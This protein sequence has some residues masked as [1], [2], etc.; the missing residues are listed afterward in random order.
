MKLIK[1]KASIL[2]PNE[3][4]EHLY[5]FPNFP[6]FMGCVNH[7][8]DEDLLVD[9]IWD[10]GVSTG[11]IQLKHLIPLDIL[12]KQSHGSGDIG[13]IWDEHHKNFAAF[14]AKYNPNSVLEVGGGHGRLAKL[15]EEHS[16]IPWTIIEPNPTP[17]EDSNVIWIEGFFDSNFVSNSNYDCYVHS[18]V[19][20]HIYE[21]YQFMEDLGK[22]TKDGD[23]LIFTIPNMQEM[24][25][26]NYTNCLNFEHTYF[27]TEPYIEYL[28]SR[29]GFK[30][31]EKNYFMDDHSIF[32]AA[33]RD[34]KVKPSQLPKN[35]YSKNKKLFMKF[36]KS[37]KEMINNYNDNLKSVN[38][39]IYL[40]GAHVFAQFLIQ[41]GL[42]ISK[43]VSILDNDNNKQGKR[44]YGTDLM[45]EPPSVL[46][47]VKSPIV[48]LK[49]GVYNQE[50]SEDIKLNIN[51]SVIFWE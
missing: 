47:D 8:K 27:L 21:P 12:Y 23:K 37:H 28:M 26:R 18:H 49:A 44:L 1:R 31:L 13:R 17:E 6:V 3:N 25:K 2:S 30:I 50:I 43:V 41:M 35:L 51:S 22:T 33:V 45:V 29:Y 14:I 16:N 46:A 34:S 42:D 19:F 15:Y 11:L 24:L 38:S 9:S 36:I 20:E 4:M 40:F 5:T 32:Y 7:P 39:P 10:I 48:I